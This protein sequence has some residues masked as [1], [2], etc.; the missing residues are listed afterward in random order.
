LVLNWNQKIDDQF[1]KSGEYRLVFY[2]SFDEPV[3]SLPLA[4]EKWQKAYSK[5]FIINQ[6]EP[7][8]QI[9][10]EICNQ[11]NQ[12]FKVNGGYYSDNWCQ[13]TISEVKK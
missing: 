10:Q 4:S 12:G 13:K 9:S 3:S 7:S 8:P 11:N 6:T 2:Y 1:V 5:T